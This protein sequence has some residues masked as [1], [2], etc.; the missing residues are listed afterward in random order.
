MKR[1]L[2]FLFKLAGADRW[3]DKTLPSYIIL[4]PNEEKERQPFTEEEQKAIWKVFET[5]NKWAG[6]ILVMIAT[7]M[8]TG[9]IR[10]LKPEMVDIDNRCICGVGMKTKVRKEATI[11]LSSNIIP[12]IIFALNDEEP[13]WQVTKE[14]FYK[15][16]YE[17][18]EQAGCRKLT[19]YSCRHTTATTLAI[20]ELVAPQTIKKVMRWSSTNMLDR[21]A[22]AAEK[23]A[24]EAVEL[25]NKKN[26]VTNNAL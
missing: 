4:P 13:L 24:R 7:G 10:R 2:T 26:E 11:Y 6:A 22:H 23:D 21:Y 20:S 5:G 14:T 12:V 17:V 15:R 8:M 18:L 19:P 1:V 16:Y 25:I 9:E 3:V